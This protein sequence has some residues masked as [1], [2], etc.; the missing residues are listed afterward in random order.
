MGPDGAYRLQGWGAGYFRVDAEG[1]LC[2]VR[3][4]GQDSETVALDA[5]AAAAEQQGLDLPLLVRF[6][7]ILRDRVRR[8]QAAFDAARA[9]LDFA[10]PY[11]PVFPIKVNQ[12]RRVVEQVLA[13]G[14]VGLEA[15]SKP[16]LLAVLALAPPG[17]VVICNGYKDREYIRLALIGRKLGREVYIVVEKP[18]ELDLIEE[19][20]A[21]LEVTPQLGLRVRLASIGAG[22]W[23]NTGGEKSKFGLSATQALAAV[24]R[25]AAAGRA[26][27][28][29]LLHFHM[30]SQIA[31]IRDIQRGLKEVGQYYASLRRLGAA[32]EVIDVG[33]G[34]A[35]DYEGAGSRGEFSMNYSLE[36][37]ARTIVRTLGE[38]IKAAGAPLPRLMSESGRGLAAHHAVLIAEVTDAELTESPRVQAG[39]AE[40]GQHLAPAPGAPAPLTELWRLHQAPPLSGPER[41]FE[42]AA[43]LAEMQ[44]MFSFGTASLEQ[45][46]QAEQ[47]YL[48][49]ALE[50]RA[51]LKQDGS[52]AAMELLEE[53][54]DKLADKFF[55]NFSLFQSLPDVW[56]LD[57]VFPIM[58]L[59]RLH[60]PTDR[61]A[62]LHDLTCDSDGAIDR[63][64][65]ALG[66]SP[67]LPLHT[68]R[69]GVPYRLGFFL[70]GAYQEILGDLHNLFGDA[71]AVNVEL[72]DDGF[73]LQHAEHGDTVAELLSYVH[74]EPA[75]L[76]ASFRRM[77][78]DAAPRAGLGAEQ[79]DWL[80]TTLEAGLS[81]YSYLEE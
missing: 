45:R 18:S 72:H 40:D 42:A 62:R 5:I 16:E 24:Q 19:E 75:E 23:Q 69:P 78:A 38:V 79:R 21:R 47:L 9:E 48:A 74:Y 67:T 65:T 81:G 76:R 17:G 59:T 61:A 37:Y 30:G 34:L 51:G 54:N 60:E 57:Q 13:A 20:A 70:V 31:N 28:F 2:V 64:T 80:L 35:V 4:P 1:R 50:V 63:Y 7:G 71:N 55:C 49:I 66:L 73:E 44:E 53:L 58:P 52:R 41:Y 22:K 56:G 32:L 3:H 43:W 39:E 12:Q 11:L 29:R 15:G 27:W 68:P 33:G 25:L 36:E 8:L 46:A 6:N 77:V 14:P 10:P 26:D